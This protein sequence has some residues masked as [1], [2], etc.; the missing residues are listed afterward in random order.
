MYALYLSAMKNQRLL[1][2]FRHIAISEGWSY[3]LLL[4]VGMPLKY[5]LEWPEPNYVI[6]MAHGFLFVLYVVWALWTGFALKW[7]LST[8]FWAGLASLLPFGTFIADRKIFK[9]M[10]S[11]LSIKEN[12]ASPM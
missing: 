8:F 4:G 11:R 1:N 12:E 5:G 6:G 3:V 10:A 7:K 2:Q 9:P